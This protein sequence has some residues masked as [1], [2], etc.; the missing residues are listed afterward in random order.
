MSIYALGFS[1]FFLAQIEDYESEFS[2]VARVS[3]VNRGELTIWSSNQKAPFRAQFHK[4]F[5]HDVTVGDFIVYSG[6][7]E[8]GPCFVEKVFNR[9]SFLSRRKAGSEHEAQAIAANVDLA[10]IISSANRDMNLN[11]LERYLSAVC[12][13]QIT[14]VVVVSKIDLMPDPNDRDLLKNSIRSIDKDVQI[15]FS[16]SQEGIGTD[17]LKS[18]LLA[19]NTAVVLGSSGV[20]K[21]SLINR[22]MG[23]QVLNTNA[24][25]FEDKGSHTTTSRHLLVLPE[26]GLIIDTPG[27]R[28]FQPMISTNELEGNFEDISQLFS[29]CRYRNCQHEKE[30]GCGVLAAIASGLLEERRW[31]NYLKIKRDQLRTESKAKGNSKSKWKKINKDYRAF[32]KHAKKYE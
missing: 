20:G 10:L 13:A 17:E 15:I 2:S 31:N 9:K 27:M 19:G 14:P 22:L 28:E 26:G 5:S 12:S 8:N 7:D 3:S 21:S 32:K 30:E 16:S 23:K 18:I 24:T 25:S 29:T 1:Q 11:R 4:G 6:N